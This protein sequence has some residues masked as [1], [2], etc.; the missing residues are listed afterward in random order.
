MNYTIVGTGNVAHFLVRKFNEAGFICDGIFGR[1]E[2]RV[3]ELA[4][5]AKAQNSGGVAQIKETGDCCILAI[6]DDAIEKVAADILFTET[7][8][9]HTAGSQSVSILQAQHKG[10]FWLVYSILQNEKI[11]ETGIPIIIEGNTDKAR[12]TLFQLASAVSKNVSICN[13][14]ERKI[15]HLA[16]VM[17]NNFTNHIMHICES[18]CNEYNLSFEILH[19]ILE[20][21]FFRIKQTSPF[22]LQTGPAKRHDAKTIE[23]QLKYLSQYPKW[24]EIYEAITRSIE[25]TYPLSGK[26]IS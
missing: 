4:T 18:L 7:T 13:E 23:N 11:S 20:Q 6:S 16:A 1:N 2:K 14:E 19:P 22:L 21:T 9:I 26:S 25:N 24:R 12:N 3:E 5:I 17:G 15:L 10:A 8:L